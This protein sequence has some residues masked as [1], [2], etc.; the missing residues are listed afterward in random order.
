HFVVS[1]AFSPDG[2][3]LASGSADRSVRL[4]DVATGRPGR[5]LA[6]RHGTVYGLAFS[7]DGS[8]LVAAGPSQAPG[9]RNEGGELTVWDVATG[10]VRFTL[11]GHAET[12]TAVAFAPD[13]ATVA[14]G[15]LDQAVRLWSAGTGEL[16]WTG[17]GRT[18]IIRA[19]AF[20][21]DGRRLA[22]AGGDAAVK[23]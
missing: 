16:L 21:A 12:V 4:W 8:F 18:G 9:L 10:Q 23:L 14:T 7:R 15:G 3:T 20:S 11:A 22:S 17:R 2:R 1:L 5:S 13:G 6:E 19:L